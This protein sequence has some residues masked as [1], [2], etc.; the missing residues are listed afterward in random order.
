MTESSPATDPFIRFAQRNARWLW[1]YGGGMVLLVFSALFWWNKVSVD[2]QRVFWRMVNQSLSTSAATVQFSQDTN[3]TS[4][5]QTV[6]Y[7]TGPQALARSLTIVRQ[8]N[9]TIKTE[10][11]GTPKANYIRYASIQ[12]DQKTKSGKPF[13]ASSLAGVWAKIS[14]DASDPA[15]VSLLYHQAVLGTGLP[16]GAMPIPLAALTS[17]ARA[18]LVREMR[19]SLLYGSSLAKPKISHEHGRLL[20]TYDLTIPPIPYVRMMKDFAIDMGLPDFNQVDPNSYQGA[21]PIPVSVTVDAHAAQLA[22]VNLAGQYVQTYSAL[23]VPVQS[24]VPAHTV[25][26]GV[27]QQRL[28]DLQ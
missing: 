22:K 19:A 13:D 23:G 18:N 25:T 1:L 14:P 16:V 9:T 28:S 26:Q 17:T 27:L 12:T 24:S 4:V 3:G 2:P 7:Q 21:Q 8:A 20:Y 6:Q 10:T 11:L 15:G 5:S